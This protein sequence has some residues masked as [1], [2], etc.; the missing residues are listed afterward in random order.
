MR[1]LLQCIL[2]NISTCFELKYVDN[3]LH[4]V[5]LEPVPGSNSSIVGLA[6][7]SGVSIPVFD[8]GLY[9]GL[10]R[11]DKYSLETPIIILSD[12]SKKVGIIVDKIIGLINIT[13]ELKQNFNELNTK[14][15]LYADIV[16]Y[17]AKS[18][19]LINANKI[20]NTAI[21]SRAHHD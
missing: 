13:D 8:L 14:T 17:D 16:D 6:N 4:L 21:M 10:E 2:N 11:R 5:Y 19:L 20:F 18:N 7:I 1:V 3:I 9:L 15:A 12:D